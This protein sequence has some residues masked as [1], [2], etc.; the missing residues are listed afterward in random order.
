MAKAVLPTLPDASGQSLVQPPAQNS[1]DPVAYLN[2]NSG[3]FDPEEYLKPELDE[4]KYGGPGGMAKAALAGAARSATFGGSDQAMVHS[5]AVDPETLKK[6]QEVNPGSSF[7]G[8]IA[9]IAAPLAAGDALGLANLPGAVSK[10]G[11]IAEGSAGLV[12]AGSM[13]AKAVG[14]GAEGAAYGLGQGISENALGDHDLLSQKTLADIGLSSAFMGGLGAVVGKIGEGGVK[15]LGDSSSAEDKYAAFKMEQ[16]AKPGSDE[17]VLSQSGLP[18]EDKLSFIKRFKAQ[19]PDAE[20]LREEFGQA[21]LPEVLGMMSDNKS[22]QKMASAVAQLPT[23]AG[24]AVRQDIDKGYEV[25]SNIL[26]DAFD[27][28]AGAD[29]AEG[30][31][32]IKDLIREEFDKRNEPMK[33][34]YSERKA[35]GETIDFDDSKSLKTYDKL[36]EASQKFREPTNEGRQ[37]IDN[38]ANNFLKNASSEGG[39]ANLDAYS[40]TLASKARQA[41]IAGDHDAKAAFLLVK[42]EVDNFVDKHLMSIG[43][44]LTKDGVKEGASEASKVVNEYKDLK[45]NYAQMKSLFSDVASTTK[46]GKKATT[47]MG[48]SEALDKVP[49]EKFV[50]KIFD[51]KN[52]EGLQ[53]IKE[54]MRPVFDALVKQKKT[55]MYQEALINKKFNPLKL[56]QDV[57]N[58]K[59][60][61]SGVKDLLFSPEQLQKMET[62]KKWITNLPDKV[63]PS[64]TPEGLEYMEMAKNPIKSLIGH[65]INEAGSSVSKRL[66]E[67][68]TNPEE[69]AQLKTLINLDKAQTKTTN[70]IERSVKDILTPFAKPIAA[71]AIS[72]ISSVEDYKE[73]TKRIAEAANNYALMEDRT[74]AATQSLFEHAPKTASAMQ[75]SMAKAMQFLNS[76]I[77]QATQPSL[78]SEAPEPSEAEISQFKRYYDIVE[79]PLL[80]LE[81]VKARAVVPETIEALNAVCPQLYQHMKQTIVDHISELKDKGSIPYQTKLSVSKFMGAPLDASMTLPSVMANQQAYAQAGQPPQG[82]QKPSKT[83]M[84]KMTLAS[85]TGVSQ[86]VDNT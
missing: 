65:G 74:S 33:Q 36:I 41:A 8:D 12:G 71:K 3:G 19:K 82:Q 18:A 67:S 30:G 43:K 24:D 58:E 54:N 83:G 10:L 1:F 34:L 72:K 23:M 7:V 79:N 37:I 21:G 60:L 51:P 68:L 39:M 73:K 38:E 59:K 46:L 26:K 27:G 78:F 25:V 29:R 66:I 81:Q 11:G 61:S 77:P 35:L 42:D 53:N 63:G 44:Q 32:Q 40:K 22:I 31:S 85:R 52:A 56:I 70:K 48:L 50:D 6:L 69:A 13:A 17:A 55:Q 9:G 64:G 28:G 62:A 75:V 76:K 15:A 5:G 86:P 47:E 84:Q 14:Y 49:D 57:S 4:E 45:R 16:A 20:A 80:A 2:S